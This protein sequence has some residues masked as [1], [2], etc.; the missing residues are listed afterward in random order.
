[1]HISASKAATRAIEQR[2]WQGEVSSKIQ[3][4]ISAG[5]VRVNIGAGA[6]LAANK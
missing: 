5:H 2:C 3:Q 6:G 1:M 4:L